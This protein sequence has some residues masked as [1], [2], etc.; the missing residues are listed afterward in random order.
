MRPKGPLFWFVMIDVAVMLIAF[1]LAWQ[2]FCWRDIYADRL[3]HL[4][5]LAIIYWA[6]FVLLAAKCLVFGFFRLYDFIRNKS[7]IDILYR[8]I[9]A[10]GLGLLFEIMFLTY[11]KVYHVDPVYP[12]N[13]IPAYTAADYVNPVYQI[14]RELAVYN[15]FFTFL[16]IVGWRAVYLYRRRKYG[17]DLVRVLI[18]G[19]GNI[20]DGVLHD[21]KEY[22]SRE[23]Q[24][25]GCVN[26]DEKG[27][28]GGVPVLGKIEQIPELV[29]ENFINDII[30]S[31]DRTS[32]E[33][34]M[35][36]MA[37]CQQTDCSLWLLPDIY[38]SIIGQ[39]NCQMAGIPLIELSSL[40]GKHKQ[41]I[42]KRFCDILISALILLICLVPIIF[43][44][45]L[46]KL[47]SRGRILHRQVRTGRYHVPFMLYKFRTMKEGAEDDSG[48][49]LALPNDPRATWVGKW[50]RR[51]H[52]DEIPQFFNVLIGNMSLVG[53]R[54]E[55]QVF[56]DRF[57][58]EIPAYRLRF[59][60]KPGI[61][62][63][64]QIHGHYQ[65]SMR[66]KLRYDIS[67]IHNFSPLMDF[68]ILIATALHILLGQRP[69]GL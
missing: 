41:L 19:P 63:M 6:S 57:E 21:I 2:L 55:R 11:I 18:V 58:E 15:A 66:H 12:W 54:P 23:H 45:I 68:K 69:R 22:S 10:V 48:P 34:L 52:L 40:R 61:T 9:L 59:E 43:I 29:Q 26:D 13:L 60:V 56:V 28:N 31:S 25:I 42:I 44:A 46:I 51:W 27:S 8:A 5:I 47:T 24:V 53:P 67:Y 1:V 39:V 17:Y 14:S 37:V 32:P 64:A 4:G 33:R 35:R 7:E 38:E 65:S 50:L 3:N 36:I 30:I 49:V 20:G 62:G 16:G